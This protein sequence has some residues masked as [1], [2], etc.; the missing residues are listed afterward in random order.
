[1]QGGSARSGTPIPS[2]GS[3]R[4][5]LAQ[6]LW[7]PGVWLRGAIGV[8]QLVG[9]Y[10]G[11]FGG[12]WGAL[13][14]SSEG[15]VVLGK[16]KVTSG[17]DPGTQT[18]PVCARSTQEQPGLCSIFTHVPTCGGTRPA[19]APGRLLGDPAVPGNGGC[20]PAGGLVWERRQAG[21]AIWDKGCARC[22][23]SG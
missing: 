17:V 13:V 22:G 11:D 8:A 18:M 6:G 10:H 20:C 16:K 12:S 9:R 23:L 4:E 1:M 3:R 15:L 2:R 19:E 21:M 7:L 14:P 5:G